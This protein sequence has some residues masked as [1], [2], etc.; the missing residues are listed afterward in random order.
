MA[1]DSPAAWK[2]DHGVQDWL[3]E[4]EKHGEEGEKEKDQENTAADN[5]TYLPT[6]EPIFFGFAAFPG[7]HV[8]K[9]DQLL[10]AT[11]LKVKPQ[12]QTTCL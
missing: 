9:Q 6:T 2:V 7:F 4:G 11:S 3:E 10:S 8:D 5:K 1:F 12:P